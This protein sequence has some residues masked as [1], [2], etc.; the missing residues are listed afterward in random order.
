[1]MTNTLTTDLRLAQ[2]APSTSQKVVIVNGSS[3]IL[4]LLDTVLDSGLYDVVFVESNNHA[5]S[6][7]KRV[8]PQLVIFCVRIERLEACQVLSMLKLDEETR[9][10]PIMTYTTEYEGRDAEKEE[11]SEPF[12]TGMFSPSLAMRMN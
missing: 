5:Y 8:M 3:E 4:N 11:P 2:L 9:N 12:D 10:I 1:M 6:Q 7:I